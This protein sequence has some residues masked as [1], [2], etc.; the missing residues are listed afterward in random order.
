MTA[1]HVSWSSGSSPNS[2]PGPPPSLLFRLAP[3]W[4][5]DNSAPGS[6]PSLRSPL[7][8]CRHH[9]R[10]PFPSTSPPRSDQSHLPPPTPPQ[11]TG[12]GATP[13]SS[14]PL[15]STFPSPR[16][17]NG[18]GCPCPQP[19][20]Q[21]FTSKNRGGGPRTSTPPRS[22]VLAL[23]LQWP[24]SI[25]FP[26]L[27]KPRKSPKCPFLPPS[28]PPSALSENAPPRSQRLSRGSFRNSAW[29]SRNNRFR[30]RGWAARAFRGSA[31][32]GIVPGK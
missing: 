14:P 28:F 32:A 9:A 27:R 31:T 13:P 12:G 19:R 3:G 22:A 17:K 26:A 24:S 2:S 16:S 25:P 15:K 7:P 18:G 1:K 5:H 23:R 4:P 30:P 8:E 11:K 20:F 21:T 29:P 10:L 6:L